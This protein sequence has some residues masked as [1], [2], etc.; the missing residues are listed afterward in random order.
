MNFFKFTGIAQV[1]ILITTSYSFGQSTKLP[2]NED[3]FIDYAPTGFVHAHEQQNF[4]QVLIEF[5]PKGETLENWTQMLSL[6]GMPIADKVPSLL[7]YSDYFFSSYKDVCEQLDLVPV[8]QEENEIIL[9]VSCL[10]KEGSNIPGGEGLRWENGVYRFVKT[11][12]MIFEIHFVSHG[13]QLPADDQNQQYMEEAR[14]AVNQVLIC[15]LNDSDPCPTLDNYTAA[16]GM[17]VRPIGDPPCRRE[18]FDCFPTATIEVTASADVQIDEPKKTGFMVVDFSSV[19]ITD[20]NVFR[21]TVI[22][23]I[24]SLKQGSPGVHLTLRGAT[25]NAEISSDDRIKAGSFISFLRMAL[26]AQKVIDPN[27]TKISFRNF[28]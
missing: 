26:V 13:Q 12:K 28:R 27:L 25:P 19:D 15:K 6:T 21:N 14:T 16:D 11:K 22:A 7:G 1:I 23:M 9:N 2:Q 18:G 4:N 24:T 3:F 10:T 5:L 20:S 17:L 8:S